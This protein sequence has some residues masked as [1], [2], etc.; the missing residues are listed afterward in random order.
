MKKATPCH[1]AASI[2]NLPI[3]V[4]LAPCTSYSSRELSTALAK[5]AEALDF[6]IRPSTRVLVKPNLVTPRDSLAVTQAEFVKAICRLVKEMGAKVTVGDSPAFGSA[7][8]V[9]SRSGLL[10][11]LKGLDIVFS[12]FDSPKRV[13]LPSGICVGISERVY[14]HD[15]IINCP[16][17]KAHSQT[18]ITAAVKNLF[19]CV[20]GFRKA[21]AH[22]RYGDV[23]TLFEEMIC[24]IPLVLPPSMSIIDAVTAMDTTGPS[25]GRAINL[26]FIGASPSPF[27]LDTALY[28]MLHAP[29][30]MLPLHREACRKN[31]PGTDPEHLSFPL[32]PPSDF[33]CSDFILPHSLQPLTFH[34]VRVLKGR[35]KSLLLRFL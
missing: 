29:L 20:C 5:I 21:F 10:Q 19:G 12:E 11:T 23:G 4:A 15:M 33:N 7:R 13:T 18:G 2:V 17:L 24:E 28:Q 22:C 14:E 35:L 1:N 31:I 26:N 9:A 8:K 16:R 27:A 34:P 32:K 6:L 25:K 30:S 3:P